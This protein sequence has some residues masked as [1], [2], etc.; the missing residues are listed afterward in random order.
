MGHGSGSTAYSVASTAFSST[1]SSD[2][3]DDEE[4]EDIVVVRPRAHLKRKVSEPISPKPSPESSS[5]PPS[6]SK[7]RGTSFETL[8]LEASALDAPY[9][10]PLRSHGPSVLRHTPR[11]LQTSP[12]FPQVF[13]FPSSYSSGSSEPWHPGFLTLSAMA[14]ADPPCDSDVKAAIA[15]LNMSKPADAVEIAS[16]PL[17]LCS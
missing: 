9:S 12:H 2:I 4:D 11:V 3:D 7:R 17:S 16:M 15:L 8:C 5:S 14:V 1:S 6:G 10:S 13:T